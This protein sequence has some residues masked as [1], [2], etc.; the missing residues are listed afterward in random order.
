MARALVRSLILYHCC[1]LGISAADAQAPSSRSRTSAA[2]MLFADSAATPAAP[3]PPVTPAPAPAPGALRQLICRGNAGTH[4]TVE[5]KPSPRSAGYVAV[6]LAYRAN[7]VPAGLG[8]DQLEPGAC[9]WT[10]VADPG[11]PREPGVVHFDLDPVGSEFIAD[12][13]SMGIWM[14]DPGHYWS[15]FV[16]DKSNVSISHGAY[17]TRFRSD[18]TPRDK[19]KTTNA[20]ALRR[21][22]LRCRGGRGYEFE[23]PTRVGPNLVA[24]KLSYRVAASPAGPAGDGLEPG[25]CAWGDRTDARQEPGRILFLTAGNAQLK[26]K[27]SGSAVDTSATAA[28]RWPDAHTIRPYLRDSTH[29]WTFTVSLANPD[30]ALNHRAW[31]PAVVAGVLSDPASE[32][33]QELQRAEP[34]PADHYDPGRSTRAGV[35]GIGAFGDTRDEAGSTTS[36][37]GMAGESIREVLASTMLASA[38]IRFVTRMGAG[39]SVI[40][41]KNSPVDEPGTGFKTFLGGAMRMYLYEKPEAITSAYTASQSGLERDTRYH[42]IIDVPGDGGRIPRQQYLGEVK[43]WGQTA[44]VTFTEITMVSDGD[45]DG[46]GDLQFTFVAED[47]TRTIGAEGDGGLQWNDGSRNQISGVS[48]TALKAD[49][50]HIHVSGVDDDQ[51]RTNRA[52]TPDPCVDS[53]APVGKNQLYEW[54]CAK[55][56]VDLNQYPGQSASIPLY[57]RSMALRNGSTLMFDVRGYVTVTRQ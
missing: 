3:A 17:G 13:E 49:R 43:T 26:Q 46:A 21:E 25:Q 55:T 15:F 50:L 22:K 5:Q 10:Q 24:V 31:K 57:F 38:A 33:P 35:A 12:P 7:P 20:G 47:G 29:Y 54:N 48:I 1:L 36:N 42:Y 27:Q 41:S 39:P 19:P 18:P 52:A 28:E 30:S 9:S 8:Y 37:I 11:V 6:L 32:A 53:Y 16:D 4:I 44:V 14:S 51:V 34:G 23:K 45:T 2:G 40:L 56:E